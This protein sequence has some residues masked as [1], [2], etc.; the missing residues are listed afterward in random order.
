M[1]NQLDLL[2]DEEGVTVA[3]AQQLHFPGP[4]RQQSRASP[5]ERVV[6]VTGMDHEL[7]DAGPKMTNHAFK[8]VGAQDAG[9]NAPRKLRYPESVPGRRPVVAPCPGQ[10]HQILER[11]PACGPS[12]WAATPHGRPPLIRHAYHRDAEPLG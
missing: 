8:R 7:S 2:L 4:R 1:T 5:D 11:L 12:F 6:D 3:R 10:H 9:V